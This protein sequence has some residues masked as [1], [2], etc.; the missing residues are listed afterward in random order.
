MAISLGN[1][2]MK[3]DDD[4][5]KVGKNKQVCELETTDGE[6]KATIAL[7]GSKDGRVEPVKRKFEGGWTMEEKKKVLEFYK[8]QVRVDTGGSSPFDTPS[9]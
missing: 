4:C 9:E 2:K 5:E 8:G 3:L 7:R 6:K 1:N